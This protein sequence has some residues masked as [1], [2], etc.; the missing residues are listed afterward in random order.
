MG[1]ISDFLKPRCLPFSTA[2]TFR[3]ARWKSVS[4]I[5][6]SAIFRGDKVRRSAER[7]SAGK[8]LPD[9]TR[10]ALT[11]AADLIT[12]ERVVLDRG[13]VASAFW[14]RRPF[15]AYSRPSKPVNIGWW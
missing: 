13:L 4:I 9:L 8:H 15:P 12:G 7:I 2:D 5:P 14:Q 10:P 6:R 3:V 1:D 11:V